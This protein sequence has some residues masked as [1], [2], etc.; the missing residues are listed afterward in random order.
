MIVD[1]FFTRRGDTPSRVAY[2]AQ[3]PPSLNSR[4]RFSFFFG[5]YPLTVVA[6]RI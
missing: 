2:H 5:S 3:P 4:R 6:I 1:G